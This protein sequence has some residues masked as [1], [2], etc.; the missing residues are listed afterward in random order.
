MRKRPKGKI[1]DDL[2]SVLF[3]VIFDLSRL[4]EDYIQV[5]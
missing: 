1:N 5:R 3:W 4:M 2:P